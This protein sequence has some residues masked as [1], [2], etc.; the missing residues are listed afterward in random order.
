M[1]EFIIDK[2]GKPAYAKVI[3]GGNDEMNDKLQERFENMPAY[4]YQQCDCRKKCCHQTKTI[5]RN[6]EI[7][8]HSYKISIAFAKK[9]QTK[10]KVKVTSSP[11]NSSVKT[12]A[13]TERKNSIQ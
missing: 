9:V 1:I 4:G 8:V 6:P 11:L 3:K 7:D 2:D 10:G 5:S 12:N 13:I